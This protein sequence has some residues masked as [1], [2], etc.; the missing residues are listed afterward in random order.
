MS[1]VER[2]HLGRKTVT[3][4]FATGLTHVTL[5]ALNLCGLF[6]LARFVRP[7]DFGL[8]AKVAAATSILSIV[9]DMGLSV[10]TIQSFRLNPEQ[11]SAL[12]WVNVAIASLVSIIMALSAPLISA[13]YGD[14]RAA[15][16]TYVFAL[17]VMLV[18]FGA[19]HTA[20]LKRELRFPSIAIVNVI[21]AT[22]GLLTATIAAVV[23]NMGYWSLLLQTVMSSASNTLGYWISSRWFP[24]FNLEFS[25]IRRHMR[26]GGNFTIASFTNHLARTGDDVLIGKYCGEQTLG[27]YSKAYELLL[28]PMRKLMAPMS[29]VAVPALS[30]LQSHPEEYRN[31]FRKGISIAMVL[32]LPIVCFAAMSG[33]D[34]ILTILGPA[35]R[36]SIPLFHALVPNLLASSTAPA[37]QWVFVSTGSTDRLVK[38]VTVNSLC[39]FIAFVF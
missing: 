17:N 10:A 26:V 27:Y 38:M 36:P 12:F 24:R 22:I 29:Q 16:V 11:R 31:F 2:K 19:Q 5:A 14:A 39:V 18:G 28:M 25:S 1:D 15:P 30:R 13:F 35:W 34:I 37:T 20:I 7:S 33:G 32:Q 21:A 9:G 8:I 6:I 4:G 3:G 23:F